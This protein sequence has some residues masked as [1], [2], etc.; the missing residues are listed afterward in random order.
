MTFDLILTL[1][2]PSVDII[3][4]IWQVKSYHPVANCFLY[5]GNPYIEGIIELFND[6]RSYVE[7]HVAFHSR[8]FYE[9]WFDEFKDVFMPYR[10]QAF[11]ELEALGVEINEYWSECD[12][13]AARG[14]ALP[15]TEFVTRFPGKILTL[16]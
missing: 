9:L 13:E 1:E 3:D 7:Y 2:K 11:S 16:G 4:I 10:E 6:D 5:E 14:T 8:K 12:I 15:A